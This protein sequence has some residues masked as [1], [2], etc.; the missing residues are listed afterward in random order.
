M[1]V[2][3]GS[4]E[5]EVDSWAELEVSALLGHLGVLNR[6]EPVVVAVDGRSGAGKST[7]AR[8]LTA[9]LTD[10]ALVSTDDIAWHFSMFDWAAELIANI[11]EPVRRGEP[12]SYR[13]P[14]W[15]ARD[16]PG[17]L[18]VAADRSLLV[19]EGVGSSQRALT[20]ALDAAVWVQSDV[21]AARRL[22][23]ERDV[24]G[25]VNGDRAASIAF[26]DEWAAAEGPFLEREAPWSRAHAMVAGV[27][28]A[29]PSGLRGV[30]VRSAGGSGAP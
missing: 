24:A 3:E 30:L 20:G 22:G 14:G 6:P 16:R 18:T 2:P 21:A 28:V 1:R 15:V 29:V 8:H 9:A 17:A 5:P 26:W 7:L 12:V 19:I 13:P 11:V 10:A 27:P 23:I 25:G 4:T